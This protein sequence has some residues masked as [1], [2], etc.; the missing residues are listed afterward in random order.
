MS[1][2]VIHL[3]NISKKYDNIVALDRVSLSIS[4]SSIVG[5]IGPDGAGKSTLMKIILTLESADEG[6]G[7]V[8]GKSIEMEKRAIRRHIGYMPEVFSLYTDL[9]V[10]ENLKFFFQIYK[11]PKS[12]CDE[13]MR[14]LYAFNRL[15][16][17]KNTQAGHLSGGMK[18]KLALSCALM[19]DPQIL[20]LDEPTTG[21]DP[22]SRAEFWKMLNQLKSGGKTILI[23]TPYLD[24]A[25]QCDYIY[26]FHQGR[27]LKQGLPDRITSEYETPFYQIETGNPISTMKKLQRSY[28]NARF[29]LIGTTIHCAI[30]TNAELSLQEIREIAGSEVSIKKITPTLEDIS[31]DLLERF[32]EIDD[33][34]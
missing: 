12:Q 16:N 8:L 13:R 9:S 30:R 5:F 28:R 26:L 24:E 32:G 7:T 19:H 22:V 23:S 2:E 33:V 18:Q 34:K 17:F 31:L 27:I 11:I 21:V 29:Y 6:S 3:E 25:M 14:M 1:E 10:E 4:R 20:V 15:E